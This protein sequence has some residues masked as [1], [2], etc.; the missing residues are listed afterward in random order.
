MAK[1][2]IKGVATRINQRNGLGDKFKRG[3]FDE[4]IAEW[5]SGKAHELNI[6]ASHRAFD[7]QSAIGKVTKL[8][9]TAKQ[10][11]FEAELIEGTQ[12]ADE[13]LT[14]I[15]SGMI[16]DISA[17]YQ[18]EYSDSDIDKMGRADIRKARLFELSVVTI[19]ADPGAKITSFAYAE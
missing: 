11:R 8:E 10:L 3:A 19:G 4:Y 17:G 7:T 16:R 2:I 15:D 6:F 13:V 14:L 1:A 12:A 18:V 9:A 5:A